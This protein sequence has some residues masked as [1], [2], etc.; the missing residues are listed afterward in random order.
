MKV[1]LLVALALAP[2][3][4]IILFMY[5]RDQYEKEPKWLLLVSFLL[6]V[7]SVVPAIFLEEILWNFDFI[8]ESA[9]MKAMFGTALVEEGCKLFF[10]LIFPYWRKAFNEPLDGILYALMVSMGFAATENIM[11]VVN[12]GWAVGVLRVFTAVPGHAM[13]A[14]TM[15]YFIGRAKFTHKNTFLLILSGFGLAVFFHG[16]YDFCLME[17]N[18]EGLWTGAFVSLISGAIL[19]IRAINTHRKLSKVQAENIK[20]TSDDEPN[21]NAAG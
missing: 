15:G 7:L 14:I 10:I 16:M 11:Y 2:V 20:T 1:V 8:R 13:F 3:V 6:G 18:L 5:Y 19:S 9:F 4:V 17:K 21:G 12:G